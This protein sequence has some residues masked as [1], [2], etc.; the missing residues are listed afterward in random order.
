M[1]ITTPVAAVLFDFDGV[2]ADTEV[3]HCRAYQAVARSLGMVLKRSEYFERY[4]GLPDRDCLAALCARAGRPSA[5]AAL[6][7]LV[8]RKRAQYALLLGEAALYPGV[9]AVLRQ[10]HRRAVL[11][12]AS[13][14][15][16]DEIEP[17]LRAAGVRSLFKAV[18]GAEDVAAG[19]PAPDPFLAALATLNRATRRALVPAQCLVIED[20]PR[21]IAAARAAGMR[22]L[23]VTTN[24]KPSAL[25]AADAVIAHV[26]QLRLSDL[27]FARE[28]AA[29]GRVRRGTRRPP[30][31]AGK[32][33]PPY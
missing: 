13:G 3:L 32:Y 18:I 11:A 6:D 4:L 25:T 27:D 2:L 33:E 20:T 15:F 14:A 29:P 28:G 21:G 24:Y 1:L 26:A 8:R 5:G 9:D 31:A 17:V 19:K 22:C 7:E 12:I 10:L 23:A 16:R 30:T